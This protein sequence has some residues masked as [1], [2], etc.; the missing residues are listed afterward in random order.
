MKF[1]LEKTDP[2]GARAGIM[3]TGH[4]EVRTPSFMPVGT[5]GAVKTLTPDELKEA[6]TQILLSNTYHL[7]LRP[8]SELVKDLGGLHSFMSWDGPILTDSGGFQM[9]SLSEL[10]KAD[11]EGIHFRSHLDGSSHH[12]TP[13]LAV[14]IQEELGT[15][16]AMCLDEVLSYPVDR[17]DMERSVKR[18]L[19]WARRCIENR[20]INSLALFGIV[21][22][23]VYDDLRSQC[24]R[25]LME[26]EFDGYAVGGLA[27]GEPRAMTWKAVTASTGVLPA[28]QPR[29]LMG[30]G[31]PEDL[32][33]GI[34][35][36]VD[37]FDCVMPTRNARNG[38][39]FTSEGKLSIKTAPLRDDTD[40]PD[41]ACKCY[42]CRNFSRA[43]LRHLYVTGEML[44][45]R[46]NTI[47]NLSYYHGL[48]FGA[49]EAIL[50]GTFSEYRSS[51]EKGWRVPEG[52]RG[53]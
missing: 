33:D 14:S 25:S 12:L 3:T 19:R 39:L 1:T 17:Q 40:P 43:Y 47:H 37:L 29:Y 46:L 20:T 24:A 44:G 32:L 11:D 8:G 2:T 52:E 34:E 31:T 10:S 48:V 27:L 7:Y 16:I 26:L 15:D 13:E 22:G 4:G 41:P 50:G 53:R 21:Q 45:F 9:M 49:R 36:G 51:V 6:G 42:T 30:M 28:G 35:R 5:Y 23:G 38:T 18:T